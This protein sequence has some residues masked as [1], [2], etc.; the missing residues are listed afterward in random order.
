MYKFIYCEHEW[1]GTKA[2]HLEGLIFSKNFCNFFAE[3]FTKIFVNTTGLK[4]RSKVTVA[5]YKQRN[6]FPIYPPG[7]V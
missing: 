2:F 3:T 6:E 5:G 4:P 7:L 1:G